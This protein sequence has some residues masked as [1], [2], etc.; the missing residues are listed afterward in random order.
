MNPCGGD[1][2]EVDFLSIQRALSDLQWVHQAVVDLSIAGTSLDLMGT[3]IIDRA[4]MFVQA[5]GASIM[6]FNEEK[7]ELEILKAWGLSDDDAKISFEPLVGFAGHAFV[8]KQLIFSNDP[9]KDKRFKKVP[10]QTTQFRSLLSSPLLVREAPIGVLNLHNKIPDEKFTDT[11]CERITLLCS[12]AGPVLGNVILFEKVQKIATVDQMTGLLRREQLP[13]LV[14]NQMAKK[15]GHPLVHMIVIDLDRFREI[16]NNQGHTK[17]DEVVTTVG[18]RLRRVFDGRD[19]ILCARWGGDEFAI[20]VFSH[21]SDEGD[22]VLE[23]I[24]TAL[25]EINV[26]GIGNLS[27]SGGVSTMPREMANYD[28]LIKDADDRMY[29]VKREKKAKEKEAKKEDTQ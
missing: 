14:Q 22:K 11:D 3:F 13:I 27:C 10:G 20:V 9:L 18:A 4:R 24:G 25:G 5:G 28:A 15:V 2:R 19:N 16:N 21:Y 23:Q 7:K 17:G 6:L 8:S 1:G 26:P 29:R 12:V